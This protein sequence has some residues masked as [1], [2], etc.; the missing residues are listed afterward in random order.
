MAVEQKVAQQ[1]IITKYVANKKHRF[2]SGVFAY[3]INFSYNFSAYYICSNKIFI[4]MQLSKNAAA[5]PIP[6]GRGTGLSY[7]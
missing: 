2:Y 5:S 7:F 1:N 4:L 6:S 3:N